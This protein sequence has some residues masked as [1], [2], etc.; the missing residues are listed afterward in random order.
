MFEIKKKI[1][2]DL[3]YKLNFM[4]KYF[5]REISFSTKEFSYF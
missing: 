1:E 4:L 3:I 2:I 5:K